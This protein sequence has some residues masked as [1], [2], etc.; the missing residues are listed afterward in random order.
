M[1]QTLLMPEIS[2]TTS[3][4]KTGLQSWTLRELC[5]VLAVTGHVL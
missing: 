5:N 1:T 2:R 4:I 3:T